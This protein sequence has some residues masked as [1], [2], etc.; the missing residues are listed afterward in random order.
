MGYCRCGADGV[1][2]TPRPEGRRGCCQLCPRAA[3]AAANDWNLWRQDA[4]WVQFVCGWVQ[5]CCCW[6]CCCYWWWWWWWCVCVCF[7]FYYCSVPYQKAP[8]RFVKPAVIEE[9]RSV[10]WWEEKKKRR[11]KKEM[12]TDTSRRSVFRGLS[13]CGRQCLS[14]P[15]RRAVG[16]QDRSEEHQLHQGGQQSHRSDMIITVLSLQPSVRHDY[17]CVVVI[18]AIGQTWLLLCCSHYSHWS[19]MI[20]TV[21]ESLQPLVR[22]DHYC[23]GVITAIGQTWLLL[24]CS[25]YSHWSDMIITVFDL[26]SLQP[27]VRHDCSH[28]S[29]QSDKTIILTVV[30]TAVSRTRL[31]FWL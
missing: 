14:S 19:D 10:C 5:V 31:L 20:I 12:D 23:V 30:I 24:C 9:I 3:D 1:G 7:T 16:C 17:Y 8:L 22:H 27:L 25:H 15:T 26:L 29:H 18:T 2:D 11:R 28:F 6:W 4:G 13:A 21:L